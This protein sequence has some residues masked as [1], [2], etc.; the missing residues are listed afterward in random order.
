MT[1]TILIVDDTA[2]NIQLVAALLDPMGYELSFANSGADALEQVKETKFDL[3]LLD[4]MMPEMDGIEVARRLKTDPDYRNIPIIFLTAKSDDDSLVEGFEVG[5]ADYVTKPFS[6]PELIARVQTH[7]ELKRTQDQLR[8]N[9]RELAEAMQMKNRL[10]GIASHDLKNPLSAISGFANMLE[11]NTT[12][13]S[14]QELTDMVHFITRASNRMMELISELLDTAALEM[15]KM[16]LNLKTCFPTYLLNQS[17]QENSFNA[18]KKSQELVFNGTN[19]EQLVADSKRLKQVFDNIISNAI[20]YS[21]KN[22]KIQI[23]LEKNADY[24][25]FRVSDQGPGFSQE[26]QEKLFGYFQRLSARPTDHE[27]S[28]GVG[29]AIVKQIVDLHQGQI[30]LEKTTSEGSTFLVTLPLTTEK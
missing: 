28:T 11:R 13:Q 20:K 2:T 1:E 14:S 10:L 24:L 5:A 19:S 30:L 9:N 18:E 23:S 21:P 25:E 22:A 16:K 15:G 12:V 29:L 3:I 17:I 8:Q 6:P 7:L 27:S 26:D 4:I